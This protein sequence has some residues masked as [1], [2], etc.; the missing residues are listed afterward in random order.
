MSLCLSVRSHGECWELLLKFIGHAQICLKSD[1]S[2]E[3]IGTSVSTLVTNT[4]IVALC[5]Q[6]CQCVY[7]YGFL[8][9]VI[10]KVNMFL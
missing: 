2:P 5:Y 7:S 3:D 6:G 9:T 1:N 4:F 8:G 10:T